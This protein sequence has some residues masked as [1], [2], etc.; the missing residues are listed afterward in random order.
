MKK[1]LFTHLP[2]TAH[3]DFVTTGTIFVVIKGQQSDGALYIKQALEKGASTIVVEQGHTL[4]QEHHDLIKQYGAALLLVPNARKSLAQLSAQ[5]AGY[6]AKKLKIFA[7]GGTKGK[8]TTTCMVG[9]LLKQL[10]KKVAFVTT[11]F[12]SLYTDRDELTEFDCEGTL[13]TPQPDYLQQFL[14]LCVEKGVDYVVLEVAVQAHTFSRIDGIE[15]DGVI[16]T[17]IDREHAELYPSMEQYFKTKCELFSHAK[18]GAPLLVNGDDL[19]GQRILQEAVQATSFGIVTESSF[20]GRLC[21]SSSLY[22][23]RAYITHAGHT[24][25]VSYSGYPGRYNLLN[26]LGAYGLLAKAGFEMTEL[27]KQ[28]LVLQ[29]VPGRLAMHKA[30]N[31]ALVCIDYAH[32]ASSFEQVLSLVRSYTS[33]LR[34]VFGA[35]G[36]KDRYKRPLMGEVAARIADKVI[37]T[38]DNP[39]FEDPTAIMADILAGVNEQHRNKVVIEHDRA[40]AIKHAYEGSTTDT[41]IMLL[42]K[43][44]DQVQIVQGKRLFFSEKQV[45]DSLS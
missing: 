44:P 29:A 16:F 35:G 32:T 10:G 31:G 20:K 27:V 2:V 37:L 30:P 7:V 25:S 38:D 21:E 28:P 45:L 36:N 42:G 9:S 39:R 8:T 26:L 41:I 18:P 43:G 1:Q 24:V 23:Q 12:I 13:T 4:S 33:D 11:A 40:K 19:Y 17:N 3:T 5:A 15:F 22:E 14:K 34:V 6:P